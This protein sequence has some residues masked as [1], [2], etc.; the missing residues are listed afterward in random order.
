MTQILRPFRHDDSEEIAAVAA[1]HRRVGWPAR[2]REGWGWLAANPARA[3]QQSP[4]GWVAV[5]AGDRPTGFAGNLVVAYPRPDGRGLT[6]ANAFSITVAEQGRG[7][8]S[9]LVRTVLRQ[10]DMFAVWTFNST[11]AAAP[12]Y[13]RLGMDA[14][15][16]LRA[17]AKL[18]WILDP[19]AC[20][21]GRAF[22]QVANRPRLV[23][24]LGERLA[25]RHLDAPDWPGPA[26][27]VRL[28][29]DVAA[30]SAWDAYRL[31]LEAEPRFRADRSPAVMAW[32][33]ADPQAARPAILFGAFE[34]PDI[35]A[36]A[37]VQPAK[38]N[39]LEVTVMEILDLDWL[40]GQHARVGDLMAGMMDLSR[41]RGAAKLRLQV[42]SHRVEAA[43]GPWRA[44][45]RVETGW[46]H[47]HLRFREGTGPGPGLMDWSP[48]PFDADHAVCLRPVP[49]HLPRRAA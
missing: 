20:A 1:L 6:G 35:V 7:T 23:S 10:P 36:H 31:R 44:R 12:L 4:L 26:R 37:Q 3:P 17:E 19:V 34:G 24:L 27:D 14:P 9:A 15:P 25:S 18:A 29:Q 33:A 28:V 41:R 45:A 30:G 21:M 16:G 5:D 11:A 47:A 46:A 40:D 2:S 49:V 39:A 32:R 48:S 8:G 43:L 22:R 42:V 38:A 13:R